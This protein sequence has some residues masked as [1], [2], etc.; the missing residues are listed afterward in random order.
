MSGMRIGSF[1]RNAS[2]ALILLMLSLNVWSQVVV[3]KS[4]DK[5]V[6]SGVTYYIHQVKK[7]E[8]AYS[9]SKAYGITVEEL[10]K[11][12]PPALYGLTTG[13]T[14]RIP[15]RP[16]AGPSASQTDTSRSFHNDSKFIYHILKPGETVYFLSKTYDVSEIEII[17]TNPGIDITKLSVGMEIAIPLKDFMSSRQKFEEP[18]KLTTIAQDKEQVPVIAPVQSQDRIQE[19]PQ[20]K[21]YILHKVQSGE[22]LSS[23]AELYGLSVRELRRANR[24]LRFPQVG[25]YVKVPGVTLPE[26]TEIVPAEADTTINIQVAPAIRMARPPGYTPVAD[27]QG[28]LDVAVLLPFYLSENALRTIVDSSMYS[29]GRK[30]V[31]VTRMGDDWIYP[32]S[33]DFIE[34]YEGILLAADTLSSLG[35]NINIHAF[36]IKNDTVELTR[37]IKEGKLEGMDLIIGPVYSR[38]LSI[39]APYA[40]NLGIPVVSPVP[41]YNNSVLYDNPELFLA[42]SSLEVAQQALAKKFGEYA[43]HNFIFVNSDSLSVDRDVQR[44]RQLILSELSKKIPYEEIKFREFPFYSRS[45]FDNDS[46]NRLSHAL[47]EG[48]KNLVV[49]ASEEAPVISEAIIDV[50]GLSKKFDIKVF[51]Y[52]VLRDLDN[53][54]PRYFFDLDLMIFSPYWID[55]SKKDVLQFNSAFRKKFLTEPTEKSYAWQGYDIAYYFISGLAIHGKEFIL[56]PEMYRPDLLQTDYDFINRAAGDGFENQNMYLIRYTKDYEVKL[57]EEENSLR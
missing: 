29:K 49:I 27:L 20:D 2:A 50:Y 53:L 28:S 11:E 7:G 8:T 31:K 21:G 14:L 24:N 51:G 40:K 35:L 34:M 16:D 26:K 48:T 3:E 57:V 9:I 38:N 41:L 1:A 30:T 15:Y 44:F 19:K 5:V 54:D 4:K 25:D 22:S 13:Q 47:S 23:I 56:H 39:V 12:N 36:D 43:D 52:P 6:I 33:M 17:Q 18:E 10:T 32:R 45:M 42:S 46:I 55:Y 37:I